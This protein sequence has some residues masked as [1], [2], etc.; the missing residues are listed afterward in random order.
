MVSNWYQLAKR[1]LVFLVLGSFGI[2]ALL[3]PDAV[4][5]LRFMED[6]FFLQPET[7]AVWALLSSLWVG[8][9][10]FRNTRLNGFA[11]LPILFYSASAV[12]VVAQN[13]SFPITPLVAYCYLIVDVFILLANDIIDD[14][15]Q[16]RRDGY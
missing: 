15:Y 8:I 3:R 6:Q 2:G 14:I 5:A 4:G 1:F 10:V 13:P 9:S 11:L 12:I 16:D 7:F